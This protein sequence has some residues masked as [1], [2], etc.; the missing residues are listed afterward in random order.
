MRTGYEVRAEVVGSLLR[1]DFLVAARKKFEAGEID[2]A[3]LKEIEDRAVED[4]IEVQTSAGIDV[5]TD[6][7]NTTTSA[8]AASSLSSTCP[9]IALSCSAW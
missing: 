8:P 5:I 6:G 4:A 3:R 2:H 9:R 7:S 1:P